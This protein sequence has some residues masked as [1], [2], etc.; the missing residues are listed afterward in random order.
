MRK[1]ALFAISLSLAGFLPLLTKAADE[2]AAEIESKPAITKITGRLPNHYGKLVDKT[3]REKIY[4]IQAKYAEKI[5]LLQEQ[6]KEIQLKRDTEIRDVLT[7][8]QQKKLGELMA[9]VKAKSKA[10]KKTEEAASK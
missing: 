6:L 5:K 7:A 9:A 8:E 1:K 10:G 3:Q 4:A 2:K